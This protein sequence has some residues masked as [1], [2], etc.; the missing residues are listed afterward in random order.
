LKKYKVRGRVQI[1]G[2]NQE[3]KPCPKAMVSSHIPIN[4]VYGE[5]KKAKVDRKVGKGLLN[6]QSAARGTPLL[7][8]TFSMTKKAMKLN[9]N[10]GEE[11]NK[12]GKSTV[13]S[14]L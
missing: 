3:G 7:P 11:K 1:R 9:I 12:K 5:T 13:V 4:D 14:V 10:T 2:E 8:D 6:G